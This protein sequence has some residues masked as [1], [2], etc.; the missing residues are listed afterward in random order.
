MGI[1]HPESK[2]PV[3]TKKAWY[4]FGGHQYSYYDPSRS[5]Y[6]KRGI[7]CQSRIVPDVANHIIGIDTREE[8][9][10]SLHCTLEHLNRLVKR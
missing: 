4:F 2:V 6:H 7:H 3:A 10:H 1:F 9:A 5:G 8:I